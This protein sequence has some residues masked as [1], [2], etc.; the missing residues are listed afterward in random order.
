MYKENGRLTP[1]D[2]KE[3]SKLTGKLF[4]CNK[5][6]NTVVI[7]GAEFGKRT[8]CSKCGGAMSECIDYF[9]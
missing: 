4:K 9:D 7:P 5:C 8:G 2:K 1:M 3:K 6:G